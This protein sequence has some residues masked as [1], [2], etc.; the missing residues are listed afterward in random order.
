MRIIF[1]SLEIGPA[2]YKE[3]TVDW[4]QFSGFSASPHH[5]DHQ[6]R[7]DHQDHQDH[8]DHQDHQDHLA[9]L[10]RILD[11]D[12]LAAKFMGLD[13]AGLFYNFSGEIPGDASGE[14]SRPTSV[15]RRGI[16]PAGARIHPQDLN[17]HRLEAVV[18]KNGTF[19]EQTVSQQPTIHPPVLFRAA[20][21]FNKTRLALAGFQM[22]QTQCLFTGNIFCR[23][24]NLQDRPWLVLKSSG[25]SSEKLA[26]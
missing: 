9:A 13:F 7:Q 17:C 25:Y 12:G 6:D 2:R 16:G 23:Y 21:N 1:L 26:I 8:H 5:Q 22:W 18:A 15:H 19:I 20:I 11:P 4:T 3:S 14:P 24:Y 10:G